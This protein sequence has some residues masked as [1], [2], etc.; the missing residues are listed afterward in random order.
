MKVKSV[1][2]RRAVTLNMGDYESVRLEL[3]AEAELDEGETLESVHKV[4][5]AKVKEALMKEMAPL[6]KVRDRRNGDAD[7]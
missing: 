6:V 4:L 1:T 5:K 2:Y 3:G 7:E